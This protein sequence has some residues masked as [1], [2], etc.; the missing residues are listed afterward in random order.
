MLQTVDCFILDTGS[1]I[2]VW[3]GKG[4]TKQEKS[5]SMVRAQGFLASK[6]YP[7]W[8]QVHR[9]VESAETAPFKQYFA[10]WR[11]RGM[12]HSRLIRAANDE[13]DSDM[14]DAEVDIQVLKNL[15]KSG[16]RAL[17][18][19]PDNGEGE[20]EVWRVENFELVPVAFNTRGFFFGGDSY[21]IKYE[22]KNKR[23]GHGFVIYYWQGKHSSQ[24]EKAASAIHATRLDS[25][26]NGKA[27][28]GEFNAH[29]R[30]R[31]HRTN[32]Y[33]K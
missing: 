13:D 15:K 24:D 27:I 12:T 8:T 7:A 11:D 26:L 21:V 16:G 20:A 18:F 4:A 3:V 14:S 31:F 1:G 17:G 5:Q 25:E 19:M 29:F 23:G 22:Y 33:S 6:K 28:Q 2:Y 10:T 32:K 9:I 30:F